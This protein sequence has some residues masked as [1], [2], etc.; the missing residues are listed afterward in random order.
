MHDSPFDNITSI[1]NSGY[2]SQDKVVDLHILQ[3]LVLQ[4][5]SLRFD[6]RRQT[7]NLGRSSNDP[8]VALPAG[9][10]LGSGCRAAYFDEQTVR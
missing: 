8:W 6:H 4:D 2:G 1:G 5:F 7:S 10:L 9:G 3:V